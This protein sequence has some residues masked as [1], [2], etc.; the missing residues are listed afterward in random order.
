MA[1]LTI[2]L[3][4]LA[5]VYVF[6]LPGT[7]VALCLQRDWPMWVR[8]AVGFTL[9]ALCIPMLSFCAAW[10]LGTSIGVAI[11]LVLATL[12]NLGAGAF[13]WLRVRSRV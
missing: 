1:V 7:L 8:V 11:P 6:V 4:V 12:V 9:S 2:L 5:L 13:W 3:Q 10:I